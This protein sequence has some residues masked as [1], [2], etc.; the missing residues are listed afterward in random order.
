MTGVR[1]EGVDAVL[2]D[3]ARVHHGDAIGHLD[4]RADVVRDEDH[5]HARLALQFA[6]QQED[7]DLHGGIERRRGLVG[8]QQARPARQ[9]QRD[10][11]ALAHAAR[12]LVRIGVESSGGLRDLHAIEEA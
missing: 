9:R 4:G 8:Q 7:L 3:A 10:H 2:D 6:Q 11:R 12:E 1:H 5:G